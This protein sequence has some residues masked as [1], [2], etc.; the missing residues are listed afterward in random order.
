MAQKDKRI[1]TKNQFEKEAWH[2]GQYVYGIDEVGRGCLAGPVVVAAV[3]L[4]QNTSYDLLKDS[5]IMTK[6][7]RNEAYAWIIKNCSY[8]LASASNHVIDSINIYQATLLCMRKA[9]IQLL[10]Q[11]HIDA[12]KLRYILID[13]MP[14][15]F[16][17]NVIP[18]HIKFEHF[19]QGE[20][21]STSIA[22]ASIVAKVSRDKLMTEACKYFPGYNFASH[23]GYAT[24]EHI[25]GIKKIGASIM[26]R[27]S[28]LSN[29]V[30]DIESQ[31]SI[32]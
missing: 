20:T 10:N 16:E 31:Q 23:K 18:E 5:K 9:V 14:L 4:P 3:M 8:S 1:I 2:K 17:A 7:Q 19:T 25:A 13:A 15:V 22:A 6:G 32:F 28:F 24:K 11:Q 29:I 30:R 27:S 26:H 12:K 21:R